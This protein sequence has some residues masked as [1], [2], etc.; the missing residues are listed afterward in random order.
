MSK[1]SMLFLKN[2]PLNYVRL[3]KNKGRAHAGNVGIKNV[4]GEYVGFLDDDD[5]FY[6]SHTSTLISFLAQSEYKVAYTDAKL[7]HK[8]YDDQEGKTVE[9]D[10]GI[11]HSRDFSYNKLLAENYIP[12][13]C[14][15]FPRKLLQNVDGFDEELDLYE[16]WDL[17]IRVGYD[18]PFYHIK[19]ATAKYNIWS[20]HLQITERAKYYGETGFAYSK[21]F[22]KHIQKLTPETI[23]SLLRERD[24]LRGVMS[25]K[26][27]IVSRKETEIERLRREMSEKEAAISTSESIISEKEAAISTSVSI[28][29]EKD[30]VISEKETEIERLHREMSE[31]E[32]AISTSESIISEKEA[33]I[34]TSVSI[35][36]EKDAVI[37]EKETEIERLHREMSEKEAVI[38]E[39]EEAQIERLHR[40]M[41]E[42]EAVI[43]EKETQ[44][45]RLHSE[46]SEKEAAI[47]E[48]EAQ[49]ERL[50]REMSEKEAVISEQEEAQIERLHREMSEKE[51][52]ISEKEAQIERLHREMSEKEAAISE[53]EAQIE[54]L[55]REMS[56]KEAA[57]SE[58]D[59][60]ITEKEAVF[61]KEE[62]EIER[63]RKGIAEKN[64]EVENLHKGILSKEVVISAKDVEIENLCRD[65]SEKDFILSELYKSLS[66]QVL[67][68]YRRVKDRLLRQDS[69]RRMLYDRG[70]RKLHNIATNKGFNNLY[71][72]IK[73]H[74]P[75][76]SFSIFLRKIKLSAFHRIKPLTIPRN[77]KAEVSIIIPVF[78][79]AKYTLN[80]INSILKNTRD[81]EYEIIVVDN[82]STDKT[83]KILKE[84]KN[85]NVLTNSENLGFGEACNIGARAANGKY[86]VFLNNDTEVKEGWLKTLLEPAARDV[87]V[88]IVGAKLV[89]PD[90]KLQEAGGIVWDDGSAWNY[91]RGDDPEKPEYNYLR[92]VDYCSA[93]CI[94]V[95]KNVFEKANG[96][97]I[98]YI[99]AYCEDS[100][101]AFTVRKLGYKVLYQPLSEVIHF[102]GITAGT[103][104]SKGI[105]KYQEINKKKFTGKWKEVLTSEHLPDGVDVF[106]AR[107][108]D[109]RKKKRMLF[110]DHYVP[111]YDK[112]A[113]SVRMFEYLKIFLE[114]EFKIVF[115]PDNL[116]KM[117][118]YTT[119]LQQMGIEVLYG[120]R[121]FDE[122]IDNFG[123]YFDV[124]YLSRAHISIKYINKIKKAT[125]AKIIYDSHDLAF[126]REMRRAEIEK[127][128][129]L[130]QE[131]SKIKKREFNLAKMGDAMIVVSLV[132]KEIMLQEDPSL[133]IY[134]LPHIH[135]LGIPSANGFK[136][137]KD[138]MFIGGFVHPPNEDGVLWFVEE[139]LPRIKDEMPDTKFYIIGSYPT[140]KIQSLASDEII[141][142]G[143]VHDVS[144]YFQTARV[145]V[146]PI[147]YGAGVKGKII[148]SMSYG[149]P[150]VTT[151]IGAEGLGLEDGNNAFIA[152]SPEEFARRVI[153]LYKDGDTWNKISKN[154]SAWMKSNFTP[155]IAKKKLSQMFHELGILN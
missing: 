31:K 29:S 76:E 75:A 8:V 24:M 73:T 1:N 140:R 106:L 59:A 152:D 132:E 45:E 10:K 87:S 43:S 21:I 46:M 5:E 97:D 11:F 61:S 35:I 113:G 62:A 23:Q 64:A 150:S 27:A 142:T 81:V 7:I 58:K 145:F 6:S 95:R 149:L 69:R 18:N 86:L 98:R 90:G 33:A 136:S 56:E 99:P 3:E 155:E 115:W 100:D 141:V 108:R 94:L 54:R 110:I 53:K 72:K 4:K 123:K 14:C 41:S 79:N 131:I 101:L 148:H 143:Y 63:L 103:D 126:L 96:F 128:P 85:I 16:D 130:M 49:I 109:C 146:A 118:P 19:K 25:E 28:I 32:A 83:G 104:I 117:E 112:D 55:H 84:M 139:I 37:S 137:R 15:I 39:Q 65:I 111:T 88:G 26:E 67:T 36:S 48:K 121:D 70:L 127:N 114:M 91:G 57:I 144:R 125:N 151:T 38:S 13:M 42:K 135:P 74:G 102:E 154:S 147:R 12:F 22:Y 129:K 71:H 119:E 107:D 80:C 116:A 51:A 68:K 66:W 153:E 138:I 120:N 44:I 134:H 78:N 17:L 77:D 89:Y 105:K 9:I 40:E 122:Y 20:E 2:I 92:E 82:A 93:A 30:A 34:S 47:S 133:V 52:A 124:I 50:R 60:V